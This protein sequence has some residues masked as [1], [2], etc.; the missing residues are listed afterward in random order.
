MD[1]TPTPDEDAAR[2]MQNL[3]DEVDKLQA[4]LAEVVR[5]VDRLSNAGGWLDRD[6]VG[7]WLSR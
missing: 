2:G 4:K 3:I 5:D 1:V 6:A 7:D